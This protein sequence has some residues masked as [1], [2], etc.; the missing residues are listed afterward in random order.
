SIMF[1]IN[2]PAPGKK[3]SQIEEYLEAYCGPGVQHIALR[4]NDALATVEAL[5]K[6]GVECLRVPDSYYE[7]VPSRV[8]RIDEPLERV[9]DVGLLV[10]AD[11]DGYLLQVFTRPVEDRPTLF[12]EIIQRKGCRGFGKG[13]FKALFESIEL[14]QAKRGNL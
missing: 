12:F 2:E 1:P 10:D 6:N 11:E 3:K 13:N 8:G 9:K 4:T 7:M 14:E 5:K